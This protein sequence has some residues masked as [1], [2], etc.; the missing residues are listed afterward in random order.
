LKQEVDADRGS[1]RD[2][3]AG[4]LRVSASALE[5]IPDDGVLAMTGVIE[6]VR[7]LVPS[8]VARRSQATRNLEG[9]VEFWMEA[10]K[11]DVLTGLRNRRG[12]EEALEREFRHAERHGHELSLVSADLDGLKRINDEFGHAAGDELLRQTA[13]LL[14]A[15]VRIDDVV[16]RLGGDEYLVVCPET[17]RAGAALLVRRI[18]RATREQ[19]ATSPLFTSINLSLGVASSQGCRTPG[20]LLEAADANL[21]SA[22]ARRSA[23]QRR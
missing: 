21:Y 14:R 12:L 22:R 3:L 20:E 9:S 11:T 10:A 17:D 7:E 15:S 16:G 23:A 2:E 19:R 13:Q 8:A 18:R 4:W 5:A 1:A 6:L